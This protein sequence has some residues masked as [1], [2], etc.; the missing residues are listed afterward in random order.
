MPYKN[1]EQQLAYMRNYRKLQRL[2]RNLSKLKE[3]KIS[4]SHRWDTDPLLKNLDPYG[5]EKMIKNMD[6]QLS[7]CQ[8]HIAYYE[9][10]LKNKD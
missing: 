9:R 4:L 6:A 2:D 7:E 8:R 5:K 1:R 10:L 3:T